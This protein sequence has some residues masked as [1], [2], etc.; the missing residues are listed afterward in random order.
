MDRA[1]RLFAIVEELRLAG[2]SGR[3]SEQLAAR[4]E[5]STRTIK[6]DISTL[7][8]GGSPIWGESRAGGGYKIMQSSNTKPAAGLTADELMALAIAVHANTETP[9]HTEAVAALTKLRRSNE[10]ASNDAAT[11]RLANIWVDG[12]PSR[13]QAGRNLDEAIRLRRVARLG[14]RDS[15][16]DETSRLVE[17]LA[18]VRSAGF[19]YLNA[20]C[21][22]RDA[23][24][25]FRLDR[26]SEVHVTNETLTPPEDGGPE[27]DPWWQ[28]SRL[29]D[30]W[31]G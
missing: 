8:I 9:F 17:P 14:Y 22:M 16:N 20:H 6:R 10:T 18:L 23:L 4:L 25:W 7:Q 2:D 12:P 21:R 11:S 15:S 5:V 1:A 3:T 19:W 29:D 24:R 26:I 28:A 27:V 30:R 31:N 13:N